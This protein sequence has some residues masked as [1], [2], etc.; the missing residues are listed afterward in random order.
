[1][2]WKTDDCL[3]LVSDDDSLLSR[4]P[5]SEMVSW[6]A[7]RIFREDL[8]SPGFACLQFDTLNDSF[9]LRQSMVR[10]KQALSDLFESRWNEPF[11]GY[12]S[13]GAF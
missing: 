12:Y 9:A 6:I 13:L 1:M 7:R 8:H 5:A 4:G 3:R 2:M 10:L 11:L